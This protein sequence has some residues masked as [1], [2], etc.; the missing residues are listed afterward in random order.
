TPGRAGVVDEDVDL[1]EPGQRVLS[2]ANDLARLAQVGG[3]P[4]RL[5][6]LR[7]PVRRRF[8]QI[9]GLARGQQDARAGLA[10]RLGDLQA[11]PARSAGHERGLARKI[12]QL[13]NGGAHVCLPEKRWADSI[14]TAPACA[15]GATPA[16]SRRR[17]R[18]CRRR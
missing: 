15:N 9:T 11:E 14:V 6:V 1:A 18:R 3:D 7:L 8:L 2:D 17:S 12:E 13:S 10:E 16:R 4:D 5:D